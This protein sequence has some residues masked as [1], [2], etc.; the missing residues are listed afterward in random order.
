MATVDERDK[1]GKSVL[2]RL[3]LGPGVPDL[4][5]GLFR[6]WSPR[7]AWL[8]GSA[9]GSGRGAA[10]S[11][12]GGLFCLSCNLREKL[13]SFFFCSYAPG[14]FLPN[15]VTLH[16][17]TSRST[18]VLSARSILHWNMTLVNGRFF[19]LPSSATSADAVPMTGFISS[20]EAVPRATV[21]QRSMSFVLIL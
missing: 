4:E 21:R 2:R 3:L 19:N 5:P 10:S 16:D 18:L 12:A 1:S 15:W 20:P 6:P 9:K 13:Y 7:L 17:L 11:R 14:F 8:Y